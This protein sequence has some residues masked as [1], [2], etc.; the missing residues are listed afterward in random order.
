MEIGLMTLQIHLHAA[1]SLKEKRSAIKS[2]SARIRARHNISV[3][4]VDHQDLLQRA[5]IAFLGVASRRDALEL[6]FDAIVQEAERCI[7]GDV[8]ETRREFLG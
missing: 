3:A 4:E 1:A 7:A 5:E 2:L 8:M 6:M